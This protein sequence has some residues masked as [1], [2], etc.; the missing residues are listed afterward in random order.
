L[1]GTLALDDLMRLLATAAVFVGNNSGPQHL[2]AGLGVSTIG[3]H[4]G[5]V[6]AREWGPLGPRAVALRR[7]MSCS[8]CYL[9]RAADCP[10]QLACLEQ[11]PVAAVYSQCRQMLA[12]A[13]S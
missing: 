8:P 10:R 6:D 3:I 12:A 9:E 13:V 7:D 1:T 5:V 11:L 4:S 2:A